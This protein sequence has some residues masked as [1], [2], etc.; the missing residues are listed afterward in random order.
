MKKWLTLFSL[1][2]VLVL[3]ACGG[4]DEGEEA[5][6]LVIGA[7]PTPHAEILD[8]VKPILKEKGIELEVKNYNDYVLPNQALESKEL[9]ANYFQHIPYLETE[10]AEKDY[11][12][13]NAGGV[14]IEPMGIYSNKYKSIDEIPDKAKVIYSS[15]T[16]DHGRNLALLE[17]EGLIKIKEGVKRGEATLEDI[18]ENPKN[19]QFAELTNSPAPEM[20]ITTYNNDEA[21]I[22]L[23]NSNFAIDGGLNPLK[24][25]I[26]IESGENNPYVNII[27]VRSED[28][29]KEEI[30]TL[31]EVLHSKEVQD[32]ITKNYDGSIIPVSE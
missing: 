9:D 12:F 6:K 3:A 25:S 18:V 11:D 17:A 5:K 28:K 23:I 8:H 7:S 21:D 15:S 20:L 1:T 13:V 22:Y 10:I 19:L 16:S 2:L 31:L 4:A 29:D 26:A 14:H 32:W 24:D 27:A 30:K